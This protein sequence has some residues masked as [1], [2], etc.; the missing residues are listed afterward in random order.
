[1]RAMKWRLPRLSPLK[2]GVAFVIL[3]LVAGVGLFQKNRIMTTIRPGATIPI[4]FAQDYRLR[5]F[6]S[7]AK[8]AGVPVGTVSSVERRRDGLTEVQVKVSGDIPR[9]LGT[10]PS[11]VIR[12]TTLLGGDYYVELEFGGQRG[13]FTG[14]IPLER[15]KIP[16]ELDKVSAA[17]QPDARAGLQSTVRNLDGTLANGGTEALRGVTSTA[18]G[19][20]GPAAGV[21]NGLQGT[22]PRTDLPQ[23]VQ[24]LEATSRVL[25]DRQHDLGGVVDD[26]R[27]TTDVLDHRSDDMATALDGMPQT[28]E[29]TDRGLDRLH[30]TI[31]KLKDTA[32]PARPVVRELDTTLA[33]LDPVLVKARPV[34][35]ELR[36]V[37]YEARPLVGQLSPVSQQLTSVLDDVRGPVLD[38][39]NGPVLNTINSPFKGT[40]I[41]AGSGSDRPFYQELAYMAANLDRATMADKN[42][43]VISFLAGAGP[44]SVAGLPISLE[45]LFRQIAAQQGGGR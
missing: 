45:Q 19:T 33:K 21:F 34:V 42:G 30:K 5:E 43:S 17:L 29:S 6:V 44:G 13:N 39:V 31:G 7:K 11:A 8:V 27:V 3:A 28:L 2:L 4:V 25:A 18:P 40:G 36:T 12:P 1:M 38:R 14:T 35:N 37:L 32:D 16:V 23:L 9:K 24:G 26:L 10:A 41:Y 20:L 22:N 15:T